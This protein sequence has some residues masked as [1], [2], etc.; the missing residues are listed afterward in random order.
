MHNRDKEGFTNC[1]VQLVLKE[2]SS[3]VNMD[4]DRIAAMNL[5]L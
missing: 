3:K 5:E 4:R 2:G 1:Y